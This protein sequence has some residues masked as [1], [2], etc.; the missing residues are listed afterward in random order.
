[1]TAV[2]ES[3]NNTLDIMD[4][5]MDFDSLIPFSEESVSAQLTSRDYI[6]KAQRHLNQSLLAMKEAKRIPDTPDEVKRVLG[7]IMDAFSIDKNEFDRILK[8][9]YK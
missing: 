6:K 9:H 4:T 1:M 7:V 8:A 2:M 3:K 5:E